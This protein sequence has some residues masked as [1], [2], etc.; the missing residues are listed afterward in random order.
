MRIVPMALFGTLAAGVLLAQAGYREE[1]ERWRKQREAALRGD[2]GWLTIAGLYWLKE[3][4]NRAGAA[5]ANEIVLPPGSAP[6]RIGAFTFRGGK[7]TFTAEPGVEVSCNGKPVQSLVLRSDA[8]DSPD[9]LRIGALSMWVIRRGD[10]YAVRLR[11]LN[12]PARKQFQGLRWFPI[13]ESWRI[14]ARWVPYNPP[15][16]VSVLNIVGIEEPAVVP[17]Y[18][19][20]QI[21]GKEYRLEPTEEA[22]RLFFVFRDLTAGKET[23]PAG[24]FLYADPPQGGAVILDFNKAYNPPCAFTAYATCPLPRPENRLPVRIPAGEMNHPAAKSPA[25]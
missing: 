17:G 24:R 13:D 2:E 6:P 25:E 18:A 3:G 20:F 4:V 21:A 1:V 10:R 22:G 12:A 7:T 8:D 5:A 11:D 16:K 14:R 19:S 15:K 23:Y 9:V